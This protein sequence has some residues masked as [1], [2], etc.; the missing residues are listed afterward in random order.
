MTK[1]VILYMLIVDFARLQAAT[2]AYILKSFNILCPSFHKVKLLIEI[3][4]I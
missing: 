2:K 3:V 4:W 1:N